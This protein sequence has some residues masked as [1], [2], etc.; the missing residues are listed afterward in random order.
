[1][2]APQKAPPAPSSS[3]PS[4]VVHDR[5]KL[6]T[7]QGRYVTLLYPLILSFLFIS[8]L[9]S[10]LNYESNPWNFFPFPSAKSSNTSRM[11]ICLVGGARRFE[12][13]GPSILEHVLNVF[14]EADLFVHS[15]LDENSFKL[16]LLRLAP[17]ITEVRIRRPVTLP[18]TEEQRK[19]LTRSNSPNGIQ[20]LLLIIDPPFSFSKLFQLLAKI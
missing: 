3:S 13:T 7:S 17:R 8:I 6:V 10:S 16:G 9:V 4:P 15:N 2:E 20:V 5:K 14:P 18:E 1:M 19:V 12:L 11:A